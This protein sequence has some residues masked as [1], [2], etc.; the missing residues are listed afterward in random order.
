MG[1]QWRYTDRLLAAAHR[2]YKAKI[3]D[4]CGGWLPHTQ[5]SSLHTGN[6]RTCK[7]E[8]DKYVQCHHCVGLANEVD[9]NKDK[10]NNVKQPH[11]LRFLT[12][13]VNPSERSGK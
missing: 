4:G 6:G 8:I 9:D 5:D 12:K 2:H 1:G 13:L 10:I 7:V 3:C 11:L